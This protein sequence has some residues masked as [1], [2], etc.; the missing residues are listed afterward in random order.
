LLDNE[1]KFNLF[2]GKAIRLGGERTS[3]GRLV[4]AIHAAVDRLGD[5]PLERD[6]AGQ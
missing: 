6:G 5:R 2:V 4:H 3:G 1:P